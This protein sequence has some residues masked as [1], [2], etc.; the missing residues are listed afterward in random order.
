MLRLKLA[1]SWIALQ[2]LF[3][4]GWAG[5]EHLRLAPGQG[6]SILVKVVPVDPRD[7]LR[8]QYMNLSYAFNRS[9][10]PSDGGGD[11]AEGETVWVVLRP[12][13]EFHI[14]RDTYRRRPKGLPSG[15][16]AVQGRAVRRRYEFG[17]EE[18]F[19]PERTPTPDYDDLTVRLRVGD[20]GR[21]RIE[22]VYLQ[23]RPWP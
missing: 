10:G 11:F 5:R 20:D 21:P 23:G 9:R 18:Y 13:G 7:L 14:P 12:E 19:V 6:R 8:G 4:G 1:A 16:V 15:E 3:F 17:I 2:V 22:R